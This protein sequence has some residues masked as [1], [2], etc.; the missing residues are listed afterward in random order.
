MVKKFGLDLNYPARITDT[1]MSFSTQGRTYEQEILSA[2]SNGQ[3]A[4]LQQAFTALHIN[5]GHTPITYVTSEPLSPTDPPPTWAM[6][7]AA[8][9]NSQG[10][11]LE[12]LLTIFPSYTIDRT[13]IQLALNHLAI[14]TLAALLHHDRALLNQDL[15][16]DSTF[17]SC[18][19]MDDNPAVALFLL[20]QG[21]DPNAG[22]FFR[23]STLRIAIMKKSL[24]LVKALVEHGADTGKVLVDAVVAGNLDVL[25]YLLNAG[26]D[27]GG[28]EAALA[29]A[30][31]D[32]R[33][34]MVTLL[35][36]RRS[37]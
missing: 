29:Q 4:I 3:I 35:N 25:R 28:V 33:A 5:P 8:I 1:E 13:L 34:D 9:R 22:F 24:R 31:K 23:L 37:I 16:H 10:P 32:E 30:G 6:L 12:Y 21:A 27:L 2:C 17:L 20:E 11:T 15:G 36:A 19:S 14:P 26:V 18:A 7:E